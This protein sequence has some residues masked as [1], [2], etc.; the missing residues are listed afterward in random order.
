MNTGAVMVDGE[1]KVVQRG[2]GE[3]PIEQFDA[4][5]Q[6]LANASGGAA[7]TTAPAGAG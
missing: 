7:S 2:S 5:V 1:G 3:I 6:S 4:A